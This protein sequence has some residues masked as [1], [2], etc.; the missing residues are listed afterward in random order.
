[1]QHKNA[2]DSVDRGFRDILNKEVPFDGVTVVFGGDFRQTLS[3]IPQRLRQEMIAASLKRGKLWEHIEVHYLVQNMWLDQ[4]PDN[5]AHAAWLLDIGAGK[6][7]GPGETVE[8]P[9]TMICGDSSIAGLVSSTYSDIGHCQ[10][11]QYYLNYSLR[12]ELW[13]RGD[14]FRSSREISRKGKNFA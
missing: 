3:V 7:L 11:D 2:I 13:C 12:Q 14:Q 9:E 5:I 1:M 10:N 4:T 8:L 6:N